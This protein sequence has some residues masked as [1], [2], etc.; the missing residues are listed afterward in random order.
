MVSDVFDSLREDFVSYF[1]GVNTYR[2]GIETSS[3]SKRISHHLHCFLEF[4]EPVFV[5]ELREY[6]SVIVDG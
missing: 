5:S 3:R 2:V 1:H 4:D 6:V